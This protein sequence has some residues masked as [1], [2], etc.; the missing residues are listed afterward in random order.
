MSL[1]DQLLDF[2]VDQVPEKKWTK[3]R[4]TYLANAD[5]NEDKLKSVST[6]ALAFLSWA[7]AS[8]K[9][10]Q[11]KKIVGPKQKKLAEAESELKIVEA[12]L[13]SK[14]AALKEV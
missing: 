6:A 10:Y 11:V 3:Y 5:Y 4:N 7:S 1:R 12:K 9:Y 2:E 8:E 13:A 14:E